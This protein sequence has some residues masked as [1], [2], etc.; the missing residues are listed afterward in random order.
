M[1]ECH[2]YNIQCRF[3]YFILFLLQNAIFFIKTKIIKYSIF[4]TSHW[5]AVL[6]CP[7]YATF[8]ILL[9]RHWTEKQKKRTIQKK[10]QKSVKKNKER[11]KNSLKTKFYDYYST[12]RNPI[13]SGGHHNIVKRFFEERRRKKETTTK[14]MFFIVSRMY[15]LRSIQFI[16]CPHFFG[17]QP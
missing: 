4:V 15:A 13:L 12:T 3:V 2:F 10:P 8:I 14:P 11:E 9:F 6:G 5:L 17:C 1:N 7:L 16:S